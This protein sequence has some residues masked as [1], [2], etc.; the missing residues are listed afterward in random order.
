MIKKIK[1]YDIEQFLNMINS[2]DEIDYIDFLSRFNRT[3]E[4]DYAPV[5]LKLYLDS[6]ATL[7]YRTTSCKREPATIKWIENLSEG[8]IFFDVGANVGAYSLIA[9]SQKEIS[10][11]FSFEP[12]FQSFYSL[13]K[14]IAI[15]NLSEKIIAV[16][17]ALGNKK[18][19]DRFN[20]W[21]DY[22]LFESGS[23]G[24]QF[25]SN[26]VITGETM[27]INYSE[28][29]MGISLDDFCNLVETIPTAIKI[30]IDGIEL[31]VLKGSHNLLR[32]KKL[33]NVM[34]ECNLCIEETISI[35]QDNGFLIDSIEEHNNI[36]F[37]RE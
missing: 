2:L 3:K 31:E 14:N 27:N 32:N 1:N 36:F 24:H 7:H 5:N 6:L 33:K 4:L 15:N 10:K 13:K 21:A 17:L 11:V 30:D 18:N 26:K 37:I 22:K 35:M 20:H 23:S 8:T 19:L 12:H 29:I 25:G 28:I 16:N 9:A 34:I